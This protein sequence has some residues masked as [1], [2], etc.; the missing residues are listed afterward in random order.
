V[1]AARHQHDQRMDRQGLR[2]QMIRP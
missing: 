2:L 1:V